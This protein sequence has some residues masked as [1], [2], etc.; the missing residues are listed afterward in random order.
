MR[1]LMSS[2]TP[3][4]SPAAWVMPP[5]TSTSMYSRMEGS[6]P[7]P[8]DV[9]HGPRHFGQG[10]ERGQD[11]GRLG[12]PGLDLDGDLRRDGQGPLGADEQLGQVVPARALDELSAGAQHGAVRQHDLEPEHVVAGHPVA[13]GAHA[14]GVGGHVASER[15]ALLAGRHRVDQPQRG[16]LAV[17]LLERHPRL[18]DGDL[19]LRVDLEDPLHA[20]EGQQDAVRRPGRPRPRAPC[21]CRGPPPAPRARSPA[22]G[23]RTPR[24]SSRAGPGREGRPARVVSASSW[25]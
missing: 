24:P 10:G 23:P 6:I 2:G 18:D 22:S 14:A 19:V 21:R 11:G 13:D 16:E 7:L 5:I 1:A 20:V 15:A 9:G 25:V 12:E 3:R 17:E 4:S 8:H